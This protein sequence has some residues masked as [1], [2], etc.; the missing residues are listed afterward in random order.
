MS[1]IMFTTVDPNGQYIEIAGCICRIGCIGPFHRM[2]QHPKTGQ[3]VQVPDYNAALNWITSQLQGGAQFPN[4]CNFQEYALNHQMMPNHTK[5]Q[6]IFVQTAA[7]SV[8]QQHVQSGQPYGPPYGQGGQTL[9]QPPLSADPLN[10]G[11]SGIEDLPDVAL[12][13]TQDSFL[14]TDPLGGTFSE[15]DK[16]GREEIRDPGLI[17]PFSTPSSQMAH[18]TQ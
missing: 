8:S 4:G 18:G 2:V 15:I 13:R 17:K 5:P 16:D 10:I 6:I 3:P 9:T 11:R 14:D 7:P 12:P 1:C